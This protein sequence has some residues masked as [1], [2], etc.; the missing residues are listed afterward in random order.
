MKTMKIK[1]FIATA[2]FFVLTSVMTA[3][4]GDKCVSQGKFIIDG[5]YGYP[6]VVGK[7]LKNISDDDDIEISRVVNTNHI[8][9]KLEFMVN[10]VIGL[11]AEYTFARVTNHI[12]NLDYNNDLGQ[13]KIVNGSF[14]ETLTKQRILFRMSIH[15]GTSES[16][17]PYVSFGAGYK[18]T[19]YRNNFPSDYPINDVNINLIPISFRA[20]IGMRWFFTEHVGLNIEGGIGGPAIQG[21][22]SV[23][24]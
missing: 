3:Q 6:Y 4:T 17:D 15:F 5:Y 8:G 14:K 9:G 1:C 20:G 10:D 19:I 23:K 24:F 11:G 18:Q 22:L 16:V 2:L 21:G 13:Y 12:K 7:V